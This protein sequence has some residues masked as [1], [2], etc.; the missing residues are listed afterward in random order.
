MK[1]PPAHAFVN[2]LI[3]LTLVLLIFS[4]S[5]GLG[6]VWMRQEISQAANR[7]RLLEVKMADVERR[8]DEVNAQVAAAVN[9]DALLRQNQV[10]RL[11]LL[12][13]REIQVVRVGESPELRLAAK[14]NREVFN[15]ATASIS[16]EANPPAFHVLTT[17]LR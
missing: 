10:M 11:G 5:L 13:P 2:R 8:L 9:P 15:V 7:G 17:A 12:S 1:P 14:R 4:G 3:G 6:A 16:D